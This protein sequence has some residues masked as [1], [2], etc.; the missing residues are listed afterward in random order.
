MVKARKKRNIS[1][2]SV[3][4][5][6][7]VSTSGYCS[8]KDRKASNRSVRT[9]KIK[10]EITQIYNESKQIY[11]APKITETIHLRGHVIA[12]KTVGNY[13]RE[14]GIR[15]IWV[16]PYVITTIDPDFDEKLKNV[17][18][19]E[20][21]PDKPNNVWVTDITYVHTLTGFL[22]LASVMDLYARK[23]VG[24]HL[25]DSLSTEGVLDAIRKAKAQR[26]IG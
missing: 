18:K 17:L 22:Y 2:N 26:Q 4:R 23:I 25:S 12:E 13:M 21:Y 8:Y 5:L 6:L 10:E 14:Q 3:L 11:G 24:W 15:A 20:V 1:V 19:R 16:S 9:K 7:V